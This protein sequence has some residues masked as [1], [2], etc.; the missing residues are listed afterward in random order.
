MLVKSGVDAPGRQ[1]HAVD[2]A[3]VQ[4]V[5]EQELKEV[6]A[7]TEKFVDP[8]DK[9]L[10]VTDWP[11]VYGEFMRPAERTGL[12]N[13]IKEDDPV[14]AIAA[15]VSCTT[16]VTEVESATVE[17]CTEVEDVQA[18]VM[19]W[20]IDAMLPV[21]VKSMLAKFNPETVTDHPPVSTTF[22]VVYDATGASKLTSELPVP[23]TAATV[24]ATMRSSCARTGDRQRTAVEVDQAAVGQ[25]AFDS[26]VVW[27]RSE[28]KKFSP[29]TVIEVMPDSGVFDI[30]CEAVG[31]S[32][33]SW[34]LLVPATAETVTN[35]FHP[36]PYTLSILQ[37][38]EVEDDHCA[39]LQL[40]EPITADIVK[41]DEPKLKPVTVTDIPT[42]TAT[43][44]FEVSEITAASNVN[45]V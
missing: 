21:A 25:A 12:S 41:S 2:V 42:E 24:M 32:K 26:C 34:M 44:T 20:P 39:G 6:I 40:N 31:A 3:D 33:L 19:Q 7:V 27:V 4:A 43:F 16:A 18:D 10:T 9:P 15:K 14:P 13:E 38:N 30:T 28:D 11:P 35:D 45:L 23:D 5:V 29:S 36:E 37:T 17:H 8:N 22:C 1:R